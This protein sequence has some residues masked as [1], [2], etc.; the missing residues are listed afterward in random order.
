MSCHPLGYIGLHSMSA[1]TRVRVGLLELHFVVMNPE[2]S[3][4]PTQLHT[5][6]SDAR[7][8]WIVDLEQRG[9]PCLIRLEY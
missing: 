9:I 8:S 4:D 5:R 7:V 3:C 2:W 1:M 6:S